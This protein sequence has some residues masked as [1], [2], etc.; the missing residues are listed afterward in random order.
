MLTWSSGKYAIG[1]TVALAILAGCSSGSQSAYTPASGMLSNA[2]QSLNPDVG[3]SRPDVNAPTMLYVTSW[4]SGTVYAYSSPRN[5]HA[6]KKNGPPACTFTA[7]Q[8]L[9]DINADAQG[10][11]IVP[12]YES[13]SDKINVYGPDCGALEGTITNRYGGA[14]D[15]T[16]SGNALTGKI[17][18]ATTSTNGSVTVCTLKAGCTTNLQIGIQYA[19]TRSVAVNHAGDCWAESQINSEEPLTYFKGCSGSAQSTTGFVNKGGYGLDFDK[20]G[21]LI[22]LDTNSNALYVYKGCN[23]ACTLVGGPL[24]LHGTGGEYYGHLDKAGDTLATMDF[25][26][27]QVKIYHYTPTSLTYL[28]SFNNG[29]S[30]CGDCTGAAYG[31]A[32]TK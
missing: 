6:N 12:S 16:S 13:G 4:A 1:V 7:S 9:Q 22:A 21:N 25:F 5:G 14:Y 23:P 10:N 27:P 31:P 11:L 8:G 30:S 26:V 2:Y 24:P 3:A 20:H 29:L 17:V 32:L 19:L 28:Y 18:V 15:V